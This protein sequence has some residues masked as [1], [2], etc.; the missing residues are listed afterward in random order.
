MK[1]LCTGRG[2]SG[3]YLIRAEQL[4]Q[5]IGAD[6]V[7]N[8]TS[9]KGY[10]A[11]IV[12]KRPRPETVAAIHRSG[13]RLIW[14]IVDAY[15][16]PEGN[17]WDKATCIDWLQR[18]VEW[19][20]PAAIVA[21]TKVMRDDCA[22][23]AVPVLALPHHARPMQRPNPIRETVK[24]VYYEGGLPYLGHWQQALDRECA[25]RGW[26]FRTSPHEMAAVDIVVALRCQTGYAARNYKSNVKLANAQGSGTPSIVNGEAGYRETA[27]FGQYFVDDE[28]Q[29]GLAMDWLT[30][31]EHRRQQVEQYRA[32]TLESV[33]QDY[34]AWLER[35]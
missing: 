4:G 20:K 35:L 9:F 16:Q 32:P 7:A 10:D 5:A 31:V 8:A 1:V 17:D 15:P 25:A 28:K 23:F 19:I 33:A 29:L 26:E 22:Q 27:S 2:K 21:A 11:V 18:E 12:V 34:R 3:S 13:I 6:V 24:I 14:D 30:P